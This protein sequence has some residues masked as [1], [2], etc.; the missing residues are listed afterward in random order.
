MAATRSLE[1]FAFIAKVHE[2]PE[3][4]IK[5][6]GAAERLREIIKIDMSDMERVEYDREVADLKANIGEKEFTLLWA[7][8]RSMTMEQAIELALMA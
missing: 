6:L 2:Q 7:E 4:A 5:I 3:R 8:G 1:C